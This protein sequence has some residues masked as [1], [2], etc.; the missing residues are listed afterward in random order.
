MDGWME[1][2]KEGWMDGWMDICMK[3]WIDGGKVE[4]MDRWRKKEGKLFQK[5]LLLQTLNSP[6]AVKQFITKG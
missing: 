1:G 4:R 3:L 5:E 2:R 6:T